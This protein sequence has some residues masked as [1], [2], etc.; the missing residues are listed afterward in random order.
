MIYA[1]LIFFYVDSVL[2]M[3]LQYRL[4]S[5]RICHDLI[6]FYDGNAAEMDKENIATKI[7]DTT[8]NCLLTELSEDTK[9]PE[10]R[11]A[12]SA[13]SISSTA[14]P[15]K[16]KKKSLS[17]CSREPLKALT[18][19]ERQQS[20]T[21][22]NNKNNGNNQQVSEMN[23]LLKWLYNT[24]SSEVVNGV[25]VEYDNTCS[26]HVEESKTRDENTPQQNDQQLCEDESLYP[27]IPCRGSSRFSSSPYQ[28][29]INKHV[30]AIKALTE[31]N[32]V[33]QEYNEWCVQAQVVERQGAAS[34]VVIMVRFPG[35]QVEY[36]KYFGGVNG[37]VAF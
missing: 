1:K 20:C 26:I 29:E 10:H 2:L 5:V 25:D 14:P 32:S 9:S 31:Y 37:N 36:P 23:W 34:G 3:L 21:G 11:R 28:Y 6:T 8:S 22:S 19:D 17:V 16:R 27:N 4:E 12:P 13:S 24:K 35:L 33:L 30:Y 18:N 7:T 15:A